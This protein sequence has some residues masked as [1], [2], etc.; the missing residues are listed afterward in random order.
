MKTLV[1]DGYNVIHAIPELE[2]MLDESL[3]AARA[4]LA[5]FASGLKGSRKDVER[6]YIVFDGKGEEGDEEESAGDGVT[7][8]YT[9]KGKDA[10][11]KIMEL[12]KDAKNPSDITVISNDN[13][14]YNNTRSLGARVKTVKELL[15][16]L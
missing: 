12:I 7:A 3:Q 11:S 5:Q 13:F 1:I 16:M 10:D 2:E 4:G 9:K 6:V 14:V 8:L 15:G